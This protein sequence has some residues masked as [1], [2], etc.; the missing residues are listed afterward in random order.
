MKIKSK[1]GKILIIIL[2]VLFLIVVGTLGINK[3][4][5]SKHASAL[6]SKVI[7]L[8]TV[9][10]ESGFDDL[11]PLESVLKDKKIV[12]IGEA[13]HG[14]KEFFQMKHRML[15]FLVTKMGYRLFAMEAGFGDAQV[16]NDYILY[17]KGN[18][19]DAVKALKYW[20]WK[21]EEVASMV[22]WMRD[23]NKDDNNKTKIKFY[24][25]D[26]QS[27]KIEKEKILNY[28]KVV[29][30]DSINKYENIFG[31]FN[32]EKLS[33]LGQDKLIN[34]K[35]NVKGLLS[36]FD[37]NKE[38]YISKSS[39]SEYEMIHQDLNIVYEFLQLNSQ[40]GMNYVNTRDNYMAENVKWI[41]NYEK[42][43]GNDK[44]M[45]WAHNGHVTKEMPNYISMG[46]HLKKMFNNDMYV[47]GMEFYK[48]NFRAYPTTKDDSSKKQSL[49]EF[50]IKS[51][52]MFTFAHSLHSLNMPLYFMDFNSV[53]KDQSTK[54]WLSKLKLIHV[55]GAEYSKYGIGS[56][57]PQVPL[58]SYDGMIFIDNISPSVGIN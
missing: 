24:G 50:T 23:Y 30:S 31:E 25:F 18:V 41:L 52:S 2:G 4:I 29:D 8:K 17:G 56:F 51:S 1:L 5:E 37:K 34:I 21:T 20:T 46:A 22:Q 44:I 39:S 40:N 3:I 11:K 12:S 35:N 33:S 36:D 32:D 49:T 10:D 57:A 45:L 6:K 58:N 26:V 42:Q 15:E 48:G 13:T 7:P 43:F 38:Q 54:Q 27:T 28:L 19:N 55:I 53:S 14:T 9:K 47:I 16:V